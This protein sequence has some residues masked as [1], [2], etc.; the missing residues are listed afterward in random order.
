MITVLLVVS[1]W[2]LAGLANMWPVRLT[3]NNQQLFDERL[4]YEKILDRLWGGFV[5]ALSGMRRVQYVGSAQER[6]TEE[7]RRA[8]GRSDG[9]RQRRHG[10]REGFLLRR[11]AGHEDA[12]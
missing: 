7:R 2:L 3:T 8:G 1:C 5:A 4:T 6:G 9:R 12:Q 10:Q 11:Q